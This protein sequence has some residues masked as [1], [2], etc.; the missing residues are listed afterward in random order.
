M[1]YFLISQKKKIMTIL[2][3]QLL[4]MEVV[5]KGD[6]EALAVLVEQISQIFLKIFLVTLEEVEEVLEDE[7]LTTEVLT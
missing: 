5:E 6:L 3:M 1:E 4:K 7:I 2:V